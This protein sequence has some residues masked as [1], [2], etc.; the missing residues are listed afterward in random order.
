V[1]LDRERRVTWVDLGRGGLSH[2]TV[3][4]G[5]SERED[6]AWDVGLD[7]KGGTGTVVG[8]GRMW[9][10]VSEGAYGLGVSCRCGRVGCV[11]ALGEQA[12]EV[13]L[14]QEGQLGVEVLEVPDL[15]HVEVPHH[16]E[17]LAPVVEVD[18]A[19]R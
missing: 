12:V 11:R 3:R 4:Y 5:M 14:G 8:F 15:A 1:G 9:R 13:D 10:G 18:A 7:R 6:L 2:G 19:Q 17:H 16:E